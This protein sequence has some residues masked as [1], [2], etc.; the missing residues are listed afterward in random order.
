MYEQLPPVSFTFILPHGNRFPSTILSCS[1]LPWSWHCDKTAVSVS[2]EPPLLA[3]ICSKSWTFLSG[4][5][6]RELLV[7]LGWLTLTHPSSGEI[8]LEIKDTGSS[9]AGSPKVLRGEAIEALC[10]GLNICHISTA[11]DLNNTH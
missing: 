9:A 8:Y 7:G 10:W 11:A 1:S 2:Q 6:A 3:W 5:Q 4:S